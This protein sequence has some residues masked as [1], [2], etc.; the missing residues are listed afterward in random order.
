VAQQKTRQQR[1]S[2]ER[3]RAQ[4]LRSQPQQSSRKP[5]LMA[6]GGVVGVIAVL[7]ALVI[8]KSLQSSPAPA[9]KSGAAPAAVV[10]NA[11]TVP[12]SAYDTV[13]YQSGVGGLAHIGGTPLTQN[14]KPLVVY[15]GADYCP[16]CA[17]ERWPLVAALSHFGTFSNLGATHSASG[18]VYPNTATFSFHGATYTSK[19]LTFN[20]VEL[21]GNRPVGNSYPKLE[22]PTALENRLIQKYDPKGTIP[23]IY[24]GNYIQ[25]SASYNPQI[26]AG[27][28][29]S[30]ISQAMRD[31][32]VT[33]SQAILGTANELTAAL[34][35]LTNGQPGG[36][37]TSKGVAA[38]AKHLP[39][40]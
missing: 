11:T 20:S 22:T 36:V 21:Y 29:M 5:M 28:T 12:A 4:R 31:P 15:I 6:A 1:R 34:C 38:A 40:K 9:K 26:L 24:I 37:C 18:D 33:Q 27:M 17:A 13:G 3:E 30:Q 8:A 35:T 16:Y 23:F 10:K 25:T 19:Y 2:E 32:Q 39:T 7:A 14:G